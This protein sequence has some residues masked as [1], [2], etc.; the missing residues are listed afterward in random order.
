MHSG[1]F[2]PWPGVQQLC[3]RGVSS[4]VYFGENLIVHGPIAVTV[5][6]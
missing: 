5:T 1:E 3:R 6:F 4:A 2:C